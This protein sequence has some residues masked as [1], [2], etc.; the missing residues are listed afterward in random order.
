[1]FATYL[2]ENVVLQ[3]TKAGAR[4]IE[5]IWTDINK[6]PKRPVKARNAHANMK[7][8]LEQHFPSLTF[9]YL[10]TSDQVQATQSLIRFIDGGFPVMM[11][12]S[13][14]R[15]DGHIILVVG[16]RNYM[17]FTSSADFRLV[18]HDPYGRF[19]PTLL[20][21]TFA[22][23]RW[24]GGVSLRSGSQVGPGQNNELPLASVG[25]QRQGDSRL[26]TFYLLSARR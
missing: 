23:K 19:D 18:V 4:D 22:G 10:Q 5:D 2:E 7:W 26:G 24:E 8:W 11:S 3:S 13:H 14:A 16:Y 25:R 17:P 15:V 20:A 6:D 21:R 9:E 1:M 12:V